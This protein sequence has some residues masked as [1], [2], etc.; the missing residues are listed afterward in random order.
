MSFLCCQVELT[1][2]FIVFILF[3]V[4][5][6]SNIK[7]YSCCQTGILCFIDFIFGALVSSSRHTNKLVSCVSLISSLVFLCLLLVVKLVNWYFVFR[8]LQ[9]FIAYKLQVF[10][11][12]YIAIGLLVFHCVFIY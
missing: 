9:C 1:S 12:C 6:F 8:H 7:F 3:L 2:C 10:N 11:N 5:C 4:H